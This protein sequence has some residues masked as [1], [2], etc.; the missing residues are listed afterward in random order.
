MAE[1]NII[2]WIYWET[3][4]PVCITNI[5]NETRGVYGLQDE[6]LRLKQFYH[7]IINQKSTSLLKRFIN[8]IFYIFVGTKEELDVF[9][10]RKCSEQTIFSKE[11]SKFYEETPTKIPFSKNNR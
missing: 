4:R 9:K 1:A 5:G 8:D 3:T 2:N 11:F 7:P 6:P 10:M